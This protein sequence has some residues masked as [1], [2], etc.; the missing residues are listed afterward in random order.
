MFVGG[1]T[2]PEGIPVFA[3]IGTYQTPSDIVSDGRYLVVVGP[4]SVSFFGGLITFHAVINGVEVQAPETAI[5]EEA[6][7]V[8][9]ENLLNTRDLHFP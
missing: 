9:Q 6:N 8:T 3:R 7:L 5:Y 1:D 2:A 4:P